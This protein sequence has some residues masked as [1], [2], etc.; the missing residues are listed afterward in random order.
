MPE[1]PL[2]QPGGEYSYQYIATTTDSYKLCVK[3]ETEEGYY[4]VSSESGTVSYVAELPGGGASDPC[5]N[6]ADTN[7]GEGPTGCDASNQRCFN[8]ECVTCGGWMNA[9]YCWYEEGSYVSCT[10]TCSDKGGVYGGNCD[11]VND[12]EDCSTVF[13][14]F[15][16]QCGGVCDGS[17]T[18]GPVFDGSEP[19]YHACY[20]HTDG[21]TDCSSHLGFY[22]ICACNE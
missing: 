18:L 21:Y 10:S 2:Y 8:D 16:E 7:W 11:W 3:S 22:R 14:F 1:D 9:G 6:H 4:C 20:Y 19:D 15:E 5:S 12:P 13:H 17:S